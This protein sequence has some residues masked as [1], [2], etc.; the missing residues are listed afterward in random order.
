MASSVAA[1]TTNDAAS[2]PKDHPT[3]TTPMTTPPTAGPARR[4]ASGRMSWSS[5]LAWASASDGSSSGTRASEAGSKN[6]VAA[7]Y[8]TAT[9]MSSHRRREPLTDNTARTPSPSA[10]TASAHSITSRR[11]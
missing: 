3:P 6:A 2:S 11:S 10:R 7:P 5:E 4:S 8:T 1:E 9:A